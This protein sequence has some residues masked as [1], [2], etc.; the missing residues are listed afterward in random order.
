MHRDEIH[1]SFVK[2][3]C[4]VAK[5][6]ATPKPVALAE[7]LAVETELKATFPCS[8]VSF[9][10]RHGPV[11]TPDVSEALGD[12]QVCVPPEEEVLAVREFL[13]PG[14]I[15]A[16]YRLCTAGGMSKDL[17]PFA[18]D[19][20]GNLFGFKREQKQP[21]PDDAAVLVF[22]HDYCVIRPEA[23]AFDAWLEYFA[24]LDL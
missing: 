2:R 22:D 16:D 18:V 9:I 3:F 19:F 23:E 10:T 15:V 17:M 6:Q 8:Y 1:S 7:L 20:G 5:G 14:R 13:S 12:C 24:S 21:R 11:F 4:F